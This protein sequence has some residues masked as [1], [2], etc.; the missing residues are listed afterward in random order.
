LTWTRRAIAEPASVVEADED[1]A[2]R[3]VGLVKAHDVH[4]TRSF[5]GPLP[6][7][8][9]S[10]A[11]D[12]PSQ[13]RGSTAFPDYGASRI[14]F[15]TPESVDDGERLSRRAPES[16]THRY[17]GLS[18]R[19]VQPSTRRLHSTLSSEELANQVPFL[20]AFDVESQKVTGAQ[21]ETAA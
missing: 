10:V 16:L 12:G 3:S 4:L 18:S 5:A 21:L 19:V 2:G 14:T 6:H 15:A 17:I 7:E 11:D 1:A 9:P 13:A 8:G 20:I